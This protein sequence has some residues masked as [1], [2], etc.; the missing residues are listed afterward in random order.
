VLFRQSRRSL[1]SLGI[2]ETID[3]A[4]GIIAGD[5][6]AKAANVNLLEIRLA[7]GMGGKTYVSLCGELA[8]VEA[9]VRSVEAK[10]KNEGVFGGHGNN[11]LTTPPANLLRKDGK[12]KN[13]KDAL[14]SCSTAGDPGHA[15]QAHPAG[16][17][18]GNRGEKF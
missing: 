7:R 6:A 10:L 16:Y 14:Y 4:S 2:F 13:G 17:A 9:A 15:L 11:P 18:Q 5:T 3:A 8:S 1:L 12:K